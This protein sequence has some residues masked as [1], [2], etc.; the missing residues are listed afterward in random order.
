MNSREERA[1][2][3]DQRRNLEVPPIVLNHGLGRADIIRSR[4]PSPAAPAP[5]PG[6]FNFPPA[7][8]PVREQ[9]DDAMATEEQLAA[10]REQIRSEVRAEFRN[11]TAAVAAAIPDAIRKKPEIPPFDKNH[12][13][14]W[15]KRTENSFI[16]ANITATNEK[17]AFLETKF[18][19]GYDPRIDEF[20][21]GD[22]TPDNWTGFLN[23]LRKEF[24]PT[25]QQRTAIFLDGFKR[26]GRKPSQYVAALNDKTKDVSIDDIKKEMMIREMPVDVRR[27]LQE[28]FDTMSLT[29]AAKVADSYFDSEG[30]PRHSNHSTGAV[31]AV[32]AS[33]ENLSLDDEEDINAVGR[34]PPQ[35]NRFRNQHYKKEPFTAFRKAEPPASTAAPIP[36]SG[37]PAGAQD[38]GKPSQS[39]RRENR[40]PPTVQ[41]LCKY[42]IQFGDGART[43]E[44][45]CEK[46]SSV[47]S[48]GKAG[49]QA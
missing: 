34:R 46:F 41:K 26:E 27:M 3:R 11:E 22:A 10:L 1:A 40:G 33:F 4:S 21:Y 19:V 25:K 29:E 44:R 23:Y 37:P 5:P 2:A 45:G 6:V 38:R 20:L 35:R 8:T 42:H 18:P 36:R 9:F 28:R 31:N 47:P 7:P 48:N 39:G 32:P 43:C 15:I 13:E 49:R 16:R 30:H 17:F 12:V 24:G 14:I